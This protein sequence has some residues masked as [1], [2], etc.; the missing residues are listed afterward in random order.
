M[1]R[2]V[3][4]RIVLRNTLFANS[5]IR[6]STLTASML[7]LSRKKLRFSLARHRSVRYQQFIRFL[8]PPA[9]KMPFRLVQQLEEHFVVIEKLL[10]GNHQ[11][12]QLRELSRKARH[13]GHN[14]IADEA[15][16]KARRATSSLEGSYSESIQNIY[17]SL[18]S[19]IFAAIGARLADGLL[20]PLHWTTLQ[21]FSRLWP[22]RF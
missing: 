5:A 4:E 22:Y 8:R 21:P 3:R 1:N 18:H 16:E 13:Q 6:I 7:G 17:F 12:G 2:A 15:E 10:E 9:T 20:G 19:P 14:D 11:V